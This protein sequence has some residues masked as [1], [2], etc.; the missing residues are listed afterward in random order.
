[1]ASWSSPYLPKLD[2]DECQLSCN[3]Q[4]VKCNGHMALCRPAPCTKW[5]SCC[6]TELAPKSR[7]SE[8][9][10]A[11]KRDLRAS[12][13]QRMPGPAPLSNQ[14][15]LFSLRGHAWGAEGSCDGI[16]NSNSSSIQREKPTSDQ[17]LYFP[18]CSFCNLYQAEYGPC[19][20]QLS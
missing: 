20:C 6:R 12:P 13:E 2:R 16:T 9:T 14:R 18:S 5:V 1:M 8:E 11:G 15:A 3:E 7:G 19:L 10:D 4:Q 17:A